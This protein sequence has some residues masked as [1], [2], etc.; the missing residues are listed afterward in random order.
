MLNL[1]MFFLLLFHGKRLFLKTRASNFWPTHKN[2][3]FHAANPGTSLH[4]R[5]VI[6]PKEGLQELL[7]QALLPLPSAWVPFFRGMRPHRGTAKGCRCLC[8]TVGASQ[9]AASQ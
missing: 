7:L 9:A 2:L 5:S 3:L 4:L 1:H 6:T 8:G